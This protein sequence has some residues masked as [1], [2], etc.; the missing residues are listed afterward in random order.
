MLSP[1]KMQEMIERAARSGDV[2]ISALAVKLNCPVRQ[3]QDVVA[4]KRAELLQQTSPV[5]RMQHYLDTVDELIG[6]ARSVYETEPIGENATALTSLVRTAQ[7][8]MKTINESRDSAAIANDVFG[9]LQHMVKQHI[10]TT[11]N[12]AGLVQQRVRDMQG[13]GELTPESAQF[14]L[15]TVDQLVRAF[16][17]RS[18]DHYRAAQ[19]E[20]S[21][22]LGVDTQNVVALLPPIE[23]KQEHGNG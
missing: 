16:G 23:Q 22:L 12:E 8:L 13:R 20:V 10:Q 2:E 7:D 6:I 14:L 21:A 3:V 18:R 19:A 5:E 9:V 11:S 1:D 15:S 4:R 17:E